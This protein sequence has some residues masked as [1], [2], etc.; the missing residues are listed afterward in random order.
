MCRFDHLTIENISDEQDKEVLCGSAIP[1]PIIVR[2]HQ[3]RVT[4]SSD[5]SITA[6]GFYITFSAENPDCK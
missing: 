3:T 6:R 4:F 1:S 5:E 2:N